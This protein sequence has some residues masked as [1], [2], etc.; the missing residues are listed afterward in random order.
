MIAARMA[1]GGSSR[2]SIAVPVAELWL[3]FILWT[4]VFRSLSAAVGA[5]IGGGGSG[6]LSH[7]FS[8]FAALEGSTRLWMVAGMVAA[9]AVLGHLLWSLRRTM[10]GSIR[11]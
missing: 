6:E 2:R 1:A 11:T 5:P 8:R 10:S 9:V 3:A 7:L 4:A